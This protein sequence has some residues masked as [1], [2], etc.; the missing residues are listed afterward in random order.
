MKRFAGV[1]VCFIMGFLPGILP[2]TSVAQK[3]VHPGIDQRPQDLEEMK[4]LVASGVQPYKA[5]FDRLKAAV[6][7][8]FT[9]KAH[10]H[11]LRGPY[12]RPNIGGD[13]LSRSANMA[14]NYALAWYITN[15]KSYAQKAISIL[16]AW[17]PVLWHFDYNDAKLLAAWTGH[18]LCNAAEILRYTNSGWKAEDITSFSNMLMT[19]YYPLIRYYYPQANGNWDGAIIH[20]ILAIAIFTDNRSMFNNAVDHYLHAPFNGSLFKYIYPSGQCQETMRDQAHVQLGLGEFA[21]AAQ[22]AYSQGTDLFSVGNN[23]LALGY[24]FTAGFLM[25]NKPHSYGTISERAKGL[26]DDYET[27]YRH[28]TAMGVV[29]PYTKRAADSVRSKASRS[30]LTAVRRFNV[31]N[32]K[33]TTLQASEFGYIAGASAASSPVAPANAIIVNAGESIQSALDSA[34]SAGKTVFLKAGIHTFPATLKIPSNIILA[35]EGI[36]TVLFL[37]PASGN[38]EAMVNASY[39]MHDVTIRDLLIEA[40]P[41]TDPGT[42]PNSGRS[43]RGGYN[44]GGIIFRSLNEGQMK[45]ISLVNVTV[46]NAT[47]NGVF[48]SGAAD[49]TV[50]RC[51]F[52][53]NGSTVV[54]GPALQHNLLLTHVNG[55][56]VKDSRLD[57]SPYGSGVAVDHC[58][59]VRVTN[60]E[61]ARN[62]YYGMLISE[63]S[64]VTIESNLV[65]ANDRT[66]IMS[67]FFSKGSSN[68]QIRNNVV[69]YNNGY[70]VESY[71]AINSK[72]EKNKYAGNGNN[73]SQEKI[74]K[75][76]IVLMR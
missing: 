15:D 74:S 27:V 8:P 51:D 12:G 33:A 34:W 28:Y 6:N 39:D 47:Y 63:C 10:T 65:E 75:E 31:S 62:G 49:V 46:Q 25:G 57:T 1:I 52:T 72:V 59:D 53:E 4:K 41:K 11:V 40:A 3:F 37:D 55:V 24:E 32:V 42:D 67:E 73:S 76:K 19:A 16:N 70:G 71:A 5:A 48:I 7:T 44:R 36:R 9:V 54:P 69:Q 64:D 45:N 23:R 14:Y 61:I 35:G 22:V 13:D 30:V 21:G 66:G 43:Y 68:V 56:S 2:V 20:S 38:R 29:I 26:R 17:S 58:S 18:M 50:E 60:C